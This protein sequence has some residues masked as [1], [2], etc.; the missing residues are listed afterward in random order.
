MVRSDQ[1]HIRQE[2][3]NDLNDVFEINCKAFKGEAEAKL[4]DKLRETAAWI[5]EL[6]LIAL[7]EDKVVGH[8]LFSRVKILSSRRNKVFDTIALAPMAVL[9]EY[10]RTGIGNLLLTNG[11]QKAK[12]M[13][14]TSVFVL[15]HKLYYPKFGFKPARLWSIKT[16]FP[17]SEKG[18]FMAIELKSNS[19]KKVSGVIEF[20]GPFYNK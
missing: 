13:Q 7:V 6:S 1:V 5:P 18:D 19:L 11:L 14:F 20:S 4:V 12:E 16:V 3:I 15:G 8:I 9:P 10:Q 2:T 17:V